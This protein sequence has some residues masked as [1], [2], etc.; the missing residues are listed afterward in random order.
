MDAHK[1]IKLAH[2][3]LND[4]AKQLHL[5]PSVNQLQTL[6]GSRTG[7]MLEADTLVYTMFSAWYVKVSMSHHWAFLV[8][9]LM[10]HRSV[11]IPNLLNGVQNGNIFSLAMLEAGITG[12]IIMGSE[13]IR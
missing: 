1:T 7:H 11:T 3:M 5:I 9:T 8:T 12:K 2:G 4:I 13:I 6:D 10:S